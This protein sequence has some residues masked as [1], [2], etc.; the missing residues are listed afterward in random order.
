MA[1]LSESN[2][3]ASR[4]A[5][6]ADAYSAAASKASS[7]D[8]TMMGAVEGSFSRPRLRVDLGFSGIGHASVGLSQ[9]RTEHRTLVTP[10]A[11]TLRREVLGLGA[12]A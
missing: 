6:T 2:L 10:L 3:P 12:T 7:I 11:N 9:R 5:A 4:P 8:S 1:G